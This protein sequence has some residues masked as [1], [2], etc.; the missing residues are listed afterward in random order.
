M[1]CGISITKWHVLAGVKKNL[2][3]PKWI[4]LKS[5]FVPPTPSS[6]VTN[7][8]TIAGHEHPTF[9]NRS[10]AANLNKTILP[11]SVGI[12]MYLFRC[13]DG[14]ATSVTASSCSSSSSCNIIAFVT[15][16]HTSQ[17]ASDTLVFRGVDKRI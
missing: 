9:S 7:N 15:D 8:T 16:N 13:P 17:D 2:R 3:R 1:W 14:S 4:F 6:A 11:V 10:C 5:G 12:Y